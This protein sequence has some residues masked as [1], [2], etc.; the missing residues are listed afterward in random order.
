MRLNGRND[1]ENWQVQFKALARSENV[2][3]IV[4]GSARA[5]PMPEEPTLPEF[6]TSLAIYGIA[7]MSQTVSKT[8]ECE[9]T[10]LIT[11]SPTYVDYQLRW[12]VYQT[13]LKLYLEEN[14]SIRNVKD[15]MRKTISPHY[16]RICCK[17]SESLKDWYNALK[18]HLS[19]SRTKVIRD[20]Q[21]EYNLAIRA[22]KLKD[23]NSWIQNWEKAIDHAIKKELPILLSVI[24]WMEDFM[25]AVQFI[26]PIWVESYKIMKKMEIEDNSLTAETVTLDFREATCHLIKG[27][28]IAK[29]GKGSFGP[30]FNADKDNDARNKLQPDKRHM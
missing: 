3:N 13:H 4:T 14:K 23:L 6:N 15:W 5:K 16:Q 28:R 11:Q 2:W 7:T 8:S 24:D 18:G 1:W 29:I 20:A 27:G 21:E 26:V 25:N 17:P 19:V 12:Q 9:H 10:G 22:P 30:T